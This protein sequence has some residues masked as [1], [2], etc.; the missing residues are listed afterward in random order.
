[1]A[2]QDPA[3]QKW[4]ALHAPSHVAATRTVLA[5]PYLPALHGPD[6]VETVACAAPKCPQASSPSQVL[7]LRTVVARPK[8]PA[9]QGA[10]HEAAVMA[11]VAP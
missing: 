7:A 2:T 8:C 5:R 4:P 9:L 3:G 1:M 11:L 6:P 10:V